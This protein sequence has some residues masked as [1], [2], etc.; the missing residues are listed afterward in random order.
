MPTDIGKIKKNTGET[1]AEKYLISLC[2]STFLS[3]WCYPC[4]YNDKLLNQ[5][6]EGKEICDV[7]VAF[8]NHIIIFSDKNCSFN[9]E[10][11]VNLAWKRWAKK[12]LFDSAA[13]INGAERWLR[14]YPDRVFIDKKCTQRLP[15]HINLKEQ[16]LHKILVTHGIDS[17]SKKYFHGGYGSLMVNTAIRGTLKHEEN[18]FHIGYIAENNEYIHVFDDFTLPLLLTNL[19]TISDFIEYLEKKEELLSTRIV[20]AC[21]EEDLLGH[22]LMNERSFALPAK[23]FQLVSF[24][25]DIWSDY[26]ELLEKTTKKKDDEV[27]YFWDELITQFSKHIMEDTQYYI[28]NHT[29]SK[30]ADLENGL[31]ELARETRFARR[32]LSNSFI[33]FMS[34]NRFPTSQEGTGAYRA[35]RLFCFE[36]RPERAYVFLILERKIEQESNL[37]YRE[38]RMHLLRACCLIAK[39]R[40]PSATTIIGIATEQLDCEERSEDFLALDATMWSE[41]DESEALK[42]QAETRLLTTKIMMHAQ[43]IEYQ[44]R[45]KIRRNAPCSCGSGIKYKKCCGKNSEDKFESCGSNV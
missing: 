14:D 18:P 4:I 9:G 5:R 34:N 8:E 12:A 11:A 37:E 43:V 20:V 38:K 44:K 6:N 42:L 39:T 41:E 15:I 19:D 33:D 10:I 30:F 26:V 29:S 27:S 21:G 16:K 45:E 31:R 1:Q 22:Y 32:I 17:F 40:I 28:P 23:D 3:M 36:Q 35:T 13:Q 2:Q 24:E 7:F 25:E